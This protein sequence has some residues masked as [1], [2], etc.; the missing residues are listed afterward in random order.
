M[1]SHVKE[2]IAKN[3]LNSLVQFVPNE[4]GTRQAIMNDFA[5]E[6]ITDTI[7]DDT[8]QIESWTVT[9]HNEWVAN[10]RVNGEVTAIKAE[11]INKCIE[12]I[13]RKYGQ[14]EQKTNEKE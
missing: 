3:F 5:K 1:K 12:S 6:L 14:N 7:D 2:N 4:D 10:V 13:K 11:S 9:E 8:I